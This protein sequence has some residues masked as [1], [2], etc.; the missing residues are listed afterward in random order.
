MAATESGGSETGAARFA[1][2]C[3]S[4]DLGVLGARTEPD[5]RAA[6]SSG[7][8]R[9]PRAGQRVVVCETVL[10]RGLGLG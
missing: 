2:Q 1:G 7:W 9:G 8:Q 3:C 5:A 4:F 6:G 10:G